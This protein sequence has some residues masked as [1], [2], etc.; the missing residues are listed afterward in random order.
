MAIKNF[1]DI[2]L[3][4]PEYGIDQ[5]IGVFTQTISI[6]APTA[7]QGSIQQQYTF[8]TGFSDSCYFQGI[9]TQNGGITYND[10]GAQTPNLSAPNPFFQSIDVEAYTNASTL[11]VYVTNYYDVVHSTSSSYTVTFKV[12][13]LAK[14]SMLYPIKPLKTNNKI[15]YSSEN[16]YQ[17]IFNKGTIAINVASGTSGSTGSITHNLG[18]IPK[19]KAFFLPSSAPTNVFAL[20]QVISPALGGAPEIYANITT[21][22]LY[23]S[24][25]QSGFGA[26]G[27]AGN[28]EWRIYYD[29]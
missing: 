13:L 20:N 1:Q 14:N 17:K 15:I 7:V 28:I 16:N 27:V 5:I 18:Y 25:D 6:A 8:S 22:T 23:F 29:S 11:H 19:V 12:Y 3:A 21:S 26:P 10:F 2:F 24:S 4:I 9:F